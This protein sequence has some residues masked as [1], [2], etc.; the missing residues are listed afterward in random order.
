MKKAVN[1]NL[2]IPTN[3]YQMLKKISE[4]EGTTVAELLREATKLSL[5]VHHIRQTPGTRLLVEREGEIRE[6]VVD[7]L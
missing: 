1:Y 2:K 7:S 6:I 4:Q 5:F 3:V